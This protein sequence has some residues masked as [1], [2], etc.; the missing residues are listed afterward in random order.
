MKIGLEIHQRLLTHKLFCNCPSELNEEKEPT[1][2]VKR[3]LHP[4]FSELGEIDLAAMAEFEK[5]RMFEYQAFARSN[6]LVELD[7]EP[8]FS[9]NMDALKIAIEIALH[10]NAKITDEV[11]VMRKIVIDGSN[12]TGF[13][14]TAIIGFNGYIETSK[15]RVGIPF[16]A[17]EEES[18]GIVEVKDDRVVYRLDRLGIPLV[19]I[20]T[21]PDIKDSEHLKEVAE[22]IGLI[23]RT[24]GKVARGIGT[25]RQDLNVSVEGGARVEIKGA[26]E[27]KLLPV[28]IENE[29]RRQK[30][31]IVVIEELRKRKA[32]GMLGEA[33]IIDVSDILTGTSS[34]LIK[35]A[36]ENG[37]VVLGV[38]LPRHAG[39]LGI[40]L[41]PGKRYGTELSDYAK[42]AGVRGIIHSDEDLFKYGFENG[43]IEGIKKRLLVGE[44]DAFVL[45]A[46]K[47]SV[48]EK[49][50]VN[51]IERAN[52]E[53]VPEETRRANPD[54]T[55]SYL[56]P[57][58][59]RAR[60]YP[61]TDVPPV[62]VDEK[63]ISEVSKKMEV[64]YESRREHLLTILNKELAEKM[65][66]S[67]HLK[68]FE[69]LV[70]DGADPVLVAVTIE[71]TLVSLRREGFELKDVDS[72]LKKVF[73][74]YKKGRFTK[75][76]IPEILKEIAMGKQPDLVMAQES[77]R[78]ISG[79]ELERIVRENDFDIK[80]IMSKYRIRIEADELMDIVKKSK[81]MR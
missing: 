50:L 14:R 74:E 57:L 70:A 69:K 64:S 56:R 77:I 26:Q 41:Q 72:V 54:G 47:R 20:S 12:T 80:K 17:L 63:L 51:V 45:V 3:Y 49:A 28:L 2:V 29:V 7:E 10:L 58:P 46:A 34:S 9:L 59:G 78:R 73:S 31:L 21:T 5:S 18:A 4:V 36:F 39:I 8:P 79:E 24:T 6:C 25:I 32:Y 33:K 60:M 75:A 42:Q 71:N 35:K 44:E 62:L 22:K 37:G 66:R 23:L 61:E 55:T 27:L 13:Q 81:D 68:L 65:L 16:I 40:E 1:V 19:E 48:A 52:I 38:R 43:E 76:A 67:K 53:R 15:G 11:H 30:R